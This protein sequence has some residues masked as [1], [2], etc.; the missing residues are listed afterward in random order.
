MGHRFQ[1]RAGSTA[2]L[3]ITNPIAPPK[4]TSLGKCSLR[5]ILEKQIAPANPYATKGTQR[6][7][8]YRCAMTVATA[9]AENTCPK[10]NPPKL[11]GLCEPLKKLSEYG[12]FPM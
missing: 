1:F 12:P 5:E 8:R 4:N 7:F 6:C 9:V 11:I 10:E 2:Y 3:E